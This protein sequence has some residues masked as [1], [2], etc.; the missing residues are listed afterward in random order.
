MRIS[1]RTRIVWVAAALPVLAIHCLARAGNRKPWF[2]K[3][4]LECPPLGAK[5]ESIHVR[6]FFQATH[7][8]TGAKPGQWTQ[9]QCEYFDDLR[10]TRKLAKM[11]LLYFVDRGA[12]KKAYDVYATKFAESVALQKER[13]PDPR[14]RVFGLLSAKRR[15]GKFLYDNVRKS[16]WGG[17]DILHKEHYFIHITAA[18]S[19][20]SDQSLSAAVDALER[21]AYRAIDLAGA[22]EERV[23]LSLRHFHPLAEGIPEGRNPG[24][25]VAT[26]TDEK[27]RLHS[28]GEDEVVFFF[29]PGEALARVFD[30]THSHADA[31]EHHILPWL[32]WHNVV[33]KRTKWVRMTKEATFNYVLGGNLDYW[34]LAEALAKGEKVRGTLHAVLLDKPHVRQPYDTTGTRAQVLARA[35]VPLE[36]TCIAHVIAVG[37]TNMSVKPV[38]TVRLK[39]DRP[40]WSGIRDVP[41]DGLPMELQKGDEIHL[42][43]H[44][45]VTI[46]WLSGFWMKAQPKRAYLKDHDYGTVCICPENAGFLRWLQSVM[47]G[48]WTGLGVSGLGVAISWGFTNPVGMGFSAA[49]GILYFLLAAAGET[50]DPLIVEMKSKVITD[51]GRD[52]TVYTLEGVAKLRRSKDEAAIHVPAGQK[53]TVSAE[54][55]IAKPSAFQRSE[56]SGELAA[57]ARDLETME[58]RRSAAPAP[59][60]TSPGG[61]P[62]APTGSRATVPVVIGI[63]AG[64]AAIIAIVFIIVARKRSS[65]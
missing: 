8:N 12:A 49:T 14:F 48:K 20:Y 36:F 19:G 32:D 18:G 30:L 41:L 31:V 15:C 64:L 47:L 24:D 50:W 44:D 34:Q 10:H 23:K 16:H 53:T 62:E 54:G 6:N 38:P 7:R 35:S 5:F 57:L 40:G 56:L 28:H 65:A 43:E 45:S 52:L 55:V 63:A 4:M 25:V 27:G 21:R 61:T 22:P 17:R 29:E 39:G 9:V 58:A 46:L 3:Q 42:R 11:D 2:E 13:G 1:H 51:F 26:I 59:T 33:V 60:G 37:S